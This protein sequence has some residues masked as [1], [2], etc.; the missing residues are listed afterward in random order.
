[1]GFLPSRQRFSRLIPYS[2]TNDKPAP[3]TREAIA[4]R[5]NGSSPPPASTVTVVRHPIA[6]HTLGILRDRRSPGSD[7]RAACHQLL[8]ALLMDATRS[9]PLQAQDGDGESDGAGS[10][11]ISKPMV[12]LAVER[13]GLGLAHRMTENFPGLVA[14]SIGHDVTPAGV[15]TQSRLRLPNAPVLGDALVLLFDPVVATGASVARACSVVRRSGATDVAVLSFVASRPG[16]EFIQTGARDLPVFTAAVDE[17]LDGRRGPLPGIG[18]LA[19][20]LFQ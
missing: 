1:M 6:Q 9:L 3:V 4:S 7:F 12:L 17:K 15:R 16:L 5:T 10:R 2:Q 19:T 11:L 13:H 20:R 8:L 14:G 18:D